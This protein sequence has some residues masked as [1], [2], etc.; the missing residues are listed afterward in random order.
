[1]VEY[2]QDKDLTA[3]VKEIIDDEANAALA[4]V[5]QQELKIEAVLKVRTNTDKEH[6]PNPGPPAKVQK[7]NDLWK[8]FT[9]AHYVLVVDYFFF[10]NAKNVEAMI[11]NALCEIDVKSVQGQIKLA[12]KKPEIQVFAATLKRYGAFD[13]I[14]QEMKEWMDGAKTRA[15]QSFAAKIATGD[16]SSHELPPEG[17]EPHAQAGNADEQ[18]RRGGRSRR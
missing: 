18:P 11:F 1:M 9:D 17:E 4:Q 16:L 10:T 15:A 2:T 7:V 12:T 8:L 6:E 5:R 14:L 3:L 13:E